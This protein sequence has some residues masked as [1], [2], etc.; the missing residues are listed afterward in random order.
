MMLN[1]RFQ[2]I[3]DACLGHDAPL[4]KERSP[5]FHLKTD[6]DVFVEIYHLFKF[7]QAIFGNQG[8]RKRSL[9]CDVVPSDAKPRRSNVLVSTIEM[10]NKYPE[11]CSGMAYLMT[12]D[13]ASEF[14][15]ASNQVRKIL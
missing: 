9:V 2:W 6:D 8:P 14:L 12:P 11:Y 7:V 1:E 10:E 3:E 4:V 5:L 13:L 15:K